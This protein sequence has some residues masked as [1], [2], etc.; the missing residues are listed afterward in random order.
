MASTESICGLEW[1]G[2]GKYY[3]DFS[4]M[5]WELDLW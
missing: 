1:D 2:L 5:L 4:W 3:A